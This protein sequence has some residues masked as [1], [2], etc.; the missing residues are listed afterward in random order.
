MHHREKPNTMKPCPYV[1]PVQVPFLS[2]GIPVLLGCFFRSIEKSPNFLKYFSR[3]PSTGDP[4]IRYN[5]GSLD[6][7]A[8]LHLQSKS[9]RAVGGEMERRTT[10][11]LVCW[12]WRKMETT[13]EGFGNL[14]NE[15]HN[16][17]QYNTRDHPT[18][19]GIGIHSLRV[20]GPKQDIVPLKWIESGFGVYCSRIPI[21]PIFYLLKG[22]Y[23]HQQ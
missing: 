5:L 2:H 8:P 16:W 22:D 23:T 21:Y 12:L 1:V 3:S 13:T 18:R 17:Q 4:A 9:L 6:L 14:R 15:K 7:D 10:V 20:Q 11:T 19:V